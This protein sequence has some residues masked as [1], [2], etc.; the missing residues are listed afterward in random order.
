MIACCE[1][2]YCKYITKEGIIDYV[3]IGKY[4]HKS[5][6]E[7]Y[8]NRESIENFMKNP[9]TCDCHKDGMCIRH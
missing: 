5:R 6:L 9:C 7:G 4:L 1:L 8:S 3:R 2:C